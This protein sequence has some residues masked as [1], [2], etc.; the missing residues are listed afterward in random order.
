M[1]E[2]KDTIEEITADISKRDE[3]LLRVKIKNHSLDS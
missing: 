1:A 2:I 3:E